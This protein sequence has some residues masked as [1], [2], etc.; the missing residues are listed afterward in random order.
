MSSPSIKGLKRFI[1]PRGVYTQITGKINRELLRIYRQVS[2]Q[3]ISKPQAKEAGEKVINDARADIL[4][5]TRKWFEKK[6]LVPTEPETTLELDEITQDKITEWRRIV[7]D[8]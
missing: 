4:R 2:A 8:M 3:T 5:L 7:D 1:I 6:G